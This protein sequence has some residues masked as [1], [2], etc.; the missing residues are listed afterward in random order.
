MNL[1][2]SAGLLYTELYTTDNRDNER[3]ASKEMIRS[4]CRL[5]TKKFK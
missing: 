4:D 5:Q 2:R 3:A 1:A